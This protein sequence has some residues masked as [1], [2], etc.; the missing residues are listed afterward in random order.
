[1][2]DSELCYMPAT[3]ALAAFRAHTL[4]PRGREARSYVQSARA[5]FGG[6]PLPA[7]LRKRVARPSFGVPFTVHSE[8]AR[9]PPG[10]MKCSMSTHRMSGMTA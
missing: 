7:R 6:N 3:E 9:V 4:S 10:S 2:D 8:Q 5:P 1:M